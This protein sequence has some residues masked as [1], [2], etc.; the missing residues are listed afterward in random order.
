MTRFCSG[1]HA[2]LDFRTRRR[3]ASTRLGSC[4]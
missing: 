2:L 1:T 4:T 3:A